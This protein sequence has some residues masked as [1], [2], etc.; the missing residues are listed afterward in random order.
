MKFLATGHLVPTSFRSIQRHPTPAVSLQ[1]IV[2]NIIILDNWLPATVFSMQL[3]SPN[4]IANQQQL[5][6]TAFS[7]QTLYYLPVHIFQLCS[8]NFSVF[9]ISCFLRVSHTNGQCYK[10]VWFVPILDIVMNTF[11]CVNPQQSITLLPVSILDN[12]Q[13]SHLEQF[14]QH[15]SHYGLQEF[16]IPTVSFTLLY[17]RVNLDSH[18]HPYL[19]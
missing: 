17:D 10:T 11:T 9:L 15:P 12:R 16:S 18:P 2:P 14:F 8:N 19:R 1:L 13:H 4:V 3:L 5:L 6:I 7:R